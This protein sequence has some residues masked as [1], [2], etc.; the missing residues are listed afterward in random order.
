MTIKF[1]QFLSKTLSTMAIDQYLF[2]T[3]SNIFIFI[4]LIYNYQSQENIKLKIS[5]DQ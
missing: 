2:G 5:L 3:F 4:L 1:E